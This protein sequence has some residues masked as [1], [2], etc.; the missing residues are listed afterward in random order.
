MSESD[1]IVLLRQQNQID[2]LNRNYIAV[3]IVLT[4]SLLLLSIYALIIGVMNRLDVK[5][6]ETIATTC[7]ALAFFGIFLFIMVLH[8][9][10][11]LSLF[12]FN[13]NNWPRYIVQTIVYSI[14]FCILITLLKWYIT[15]SVLA[16]RDI[17]IFDHGNLVHMGM[18][19][20][21]HGL[22]IV[23]LALIYVLFV[24]LQAF[25]VNGAVQSSIIHFVHFKQA[26]LLSVFSSTLLFAAMHVSIDFFFAVCML[27]PGVF[28]AILYARQ[29]SLLGVMVS[30]AIIGIYGL[31]LL[32]YGP[33][34]VAIE[35][36]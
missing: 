18:H 24:P 26:K 36:M 3:S 20:K 9:K 15:E 4:Y 6:G 14:M 27:I 33:F 32:G 19:G 25:I 31:Y 2:I 12:G 10:E 23:L 5:Y 1:K 28:W 13:L 16:L 22:F 17:P 30:H 21:F 34:V 35:K 11:P 7:F 29:Q 8:T